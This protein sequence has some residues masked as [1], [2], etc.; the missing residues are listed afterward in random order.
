MDGSTGCCHNFSVYNW[1]K[2]YSNNSKLLFSQ[3]GGKPQ[4]EFLLRP[5]K[6][7]PTSSCLCHIDW[8]K[9][10][11]S[12]ADDQPVKVHDLECC[13]F[14]NGKR[15]TSLPSRTLVLMGEL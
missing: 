8:S 10:A 9:K 2:C 7:T 6:L 11:I 1:F 14:V 3:F 15:N 12:V 5:K 4:T 13:S